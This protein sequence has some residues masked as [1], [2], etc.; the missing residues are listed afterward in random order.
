MKE[1]SYQ[2]TA[3]N[4]L[5]GTREAISRPMPLEVAIVRMERER[6]S[7]KRLRYQ[8]YKQLR[9][10]KVEPIQLKLNFEEDE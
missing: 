8:P 6:E 9:V 1:P 4:V 7:R 5:T 10:D 2:I 3:I